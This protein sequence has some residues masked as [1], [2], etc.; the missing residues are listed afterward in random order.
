MPAQVDP[1]EH[2]ENFENSTDAP[3]KSRMRPKAR[4]LRRYKSKKYLSLEKKVGTLKKVSTGL[5]ALWLITLVAGYSSLEAMGEDKKKLF[6]VV[7]DQ[8]EQI[9]QLQVHIE[10]LSAEK[11][12]LVAGRIPGLRPFVINEVE[13]DVSQYV[14][15]ILLTSK[16]NGGHHNYVAILHNQSNEDVTPIVDILLFDELGI[17]VARAG[18]TSDETP[19]LSRDAKLQPGESRSYTGKLKVRDD[20]VPKYLLVT[21]RDK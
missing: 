9:S 21:S 4:L 8:R 2:T 18:V 13:K 15:S 19:Q 5:A 7:D 20:S 14:E 16:G 1:I 12:S 3:G 6:R 11:S 10:T 17:Q